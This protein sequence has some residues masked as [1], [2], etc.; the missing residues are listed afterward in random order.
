MAHCTLSSTRSNGRYSAQ[1]PR[2]PA[3]QRHIIIDT[4][5]AAAPTCGS[6]KAV[7]EAL[8]YPHA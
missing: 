4:P 6:A 8:F 1:A 7:R 5:N 3:D 2:T